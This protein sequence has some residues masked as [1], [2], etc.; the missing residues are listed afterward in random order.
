[1]NEKAQQGEFLSPV[2]SE[3]RYRRVDGAS[4]SSLPRLFDWTRG[5]GVTELRDLSNGRTTKV[6]IR[7]AIGAITIGQLD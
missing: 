2:R 5:D 3:L 1:M 4:S 7:S 6:S